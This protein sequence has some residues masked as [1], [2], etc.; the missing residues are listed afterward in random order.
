MIVLLPFGNFTK[1]SLISNDTVFIRRSVANC[2][3][4]QFIY[5]LAYGGN[6]CLAFYATNIIYYSLRIDNIIAVVFGIPS[7]SSGLVSTPQL[8][9]L[10]ARYVF[11]FNNLSYLSE[12]SDIIQ[13]DWYLHKYCSEQP[14]FHQRPFRGRYI[15]LYLWNVNYK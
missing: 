10:S 14:L 1:P 6:H 2:I 3:K 8:S 7:V 12:H 5:R 11:L 15:P 13:P 9:K 4:H